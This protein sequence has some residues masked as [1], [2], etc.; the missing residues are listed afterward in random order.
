MVFLIWSR[1]GFLTIPIVIGT[2]IVVGGILQ[3]LLAAAGRADLT[4]LAISAGIFAG[5]AANWFIGKRMNAAE[6]RVLID[7][8]TNQQVV[9][10]RLHKLFW[11]RVE[12]WSIPVAILG[13]VPLLA[14][15][16]S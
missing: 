5:A 1:W 14:I 8:A 13:F 16:G 10:H 4:Y 6:P 9:L 7:P 11:I 3:A 12:Y 2:S 15:F